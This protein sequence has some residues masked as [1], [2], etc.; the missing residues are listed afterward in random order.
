MKKVCLSYSADNN[1]LDYIKTSVFSLNSTS[2]GVYAHVDLINSDDRSLEKLN[3]VI[4]KHTKVEE[5]FDTNHVIIKNKHSEIL[6]ERF[7]KL[8]GAYANLRKVYNIF[9]ILNEYDFDY[10]IN[11]DADNIITKNL[12]NFFSDLNVDSDLLLKYA[13]KERLV[14]EKLEKRYFNFKDFDITK[15]NLENLDVHFREGCLVVCNTQTSKDFFKYVSENILKKIAWYGDSYWITR[16]YLNFKEKI[17]IIELPNDFVNYNIS[18]DSTFEPYVI[19]GYGENKHSGA[20]A[21][22]ARAY[23]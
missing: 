6:K 13:S 16:A 14:G 11:M 15:L 2:P 8:T 23:A 10:V 21:K 3:N 9:Y 5:F 7:V 18:N 12:M 20:Y 19:S 17:K 22:I 4:L 1:Y